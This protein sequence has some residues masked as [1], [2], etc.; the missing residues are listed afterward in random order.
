MA[1]LDDKSIVSSGAMGRISRSPTG[2]STA[3]SPMSQS[4]SDL[5]ARWADISDGEYETEWDSFDATNS[6]SPK[7]MADLR[8][9]SSMLLDSEPAS[10]ETTPRVGEEPRLNIY[11]PEF[12]P[13]QTMDCPLVGICTVIPEDGVIDIQELLSQS[14]SQ[15]QKKKKPY[16][17]SKAPQDLAAKKLATSVA[18]SALDPLEIKE[19]SNDR[20]SLFATQPYLPPYASCEMPEASEEEWQHRVEIRRRQLDAGF[21]SKEYL[22]YVQHMKHCD[23]AELIV[24]PDPTDRSIAKRQWKYQLQLWRDALMRHWMNRLIESGK[25]EGGSVV[26]TEEDEADGS[27]ADDDLSTITHH[28]EVADDASSSSW[29]AR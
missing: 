17:R 26:S 3:A 7:W 16:W 20:H 8:M 4:R 25:P 21:Q 10:A 22:W 11:A 23:V 6:H 19:E 9:S 29:S 5:G 14:S 1:C 12:V 28:S 13:T 18:E 2:V 24:G 15:G 27:E